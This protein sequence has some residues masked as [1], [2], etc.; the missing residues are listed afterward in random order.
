VLAPFLYLSIIISA[1]MDWVVFHR[2]PNG[3]SIVGAVLVISGGLIQIHTR[4][5]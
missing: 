1:I 4:K 2:I 3:L 5:K